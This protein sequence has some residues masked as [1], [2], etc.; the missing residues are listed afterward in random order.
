MIFLK[1]L[2]YHYIPS[3][4]ELQDHSV[5]NIKY[6]WYKKRFMFCR[7]IL[8]KLGLHWWDKEASANGHRM[9]Y[10]CDIW[11]VKQRESGKLKR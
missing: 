6:Y 7:K 9:C 5:I 8:C 10:N 11:L 4:V 3:E 2:P 1:R